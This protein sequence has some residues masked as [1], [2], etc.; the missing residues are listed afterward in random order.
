MELKITGCNDCPFNYNPMD[1][2]TTDVCQHPII[3][4]REL[5]YLKGGVTYKY[6]EGESPEWCPLKKEPITITQQSYFK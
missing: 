2:W 3:V 6:E 4:E 5:S 1:G